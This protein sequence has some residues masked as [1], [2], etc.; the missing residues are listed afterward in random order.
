M[1][2]NNPTYKRTEGEKEQD[3]EFVLDLYLK[4][5]SFTAIT[6]SLNGAREYNVSRTQVTKDIKKEV[7]LWKHERLDNIDESVQQEIQKINVLEM[8]YW[9][10]WIKSQKT[11]KI[12]TTSAKNNVNEQKKIVGSTEISKTERQEESVGDVRFLQGV[13]R[14]IQKRCE[15]SGL[16]KAKE[17]VIS[18]KLEHTTFELFTENYPLK[19]AK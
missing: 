19:V 16:D 12:S 10:A 17:I 13:E 9:K 11:R 4:G 7:E 5:F 3:K 15:L 1:K 14:C 2:K 8:E 6:D 18:G